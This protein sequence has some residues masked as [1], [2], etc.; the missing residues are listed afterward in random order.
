MSSHNVGNKHNLLHT[1]GSY[2]EQDSA[3]FPVGRV[4]KFPESTLL[5]MIPTDQNE[6]LI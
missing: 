1:D 4:F 3:L 2:I 5:S 6:E